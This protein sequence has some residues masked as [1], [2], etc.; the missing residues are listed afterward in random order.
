MNYLSE[1]LKEPVDVPVVSAVRWL[2]VALDDA[3]AARWVVGGRAPASYGT[4]IAA[5]RGQ[6]LHV[7]TLKSTA[8]VE[9]ADMRIVTR[10]RV[11]K[12]RLREALSATRAALREMREAIDARLNADPTVPR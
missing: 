5:Y 3:G 9:C 11:S 1:Q 12:R 7:L 8:V 6:V 4:R 10:R 2:T